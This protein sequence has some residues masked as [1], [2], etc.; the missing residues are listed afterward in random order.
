MLTY[1]GKSGNRGD[2]LI[3]VLFAVAIFSLVAVG[4]LSIMNQGTATAQRSLEIT[5]VRQ[6]IDAQAE[7]L[8]YLNASYIVG[9]SGSSEWQQI[10]NFAQD[11]NLTASAFNST[12]CVIPANTFILNT[13]T[14]KYVEPSG[15]GKPGFATTY[16]Q[17]RYDYNANTNN[18]TIHSVEGIWI[19]PV[20]SPT[21]IIPDQADAGYID[22][23][24]RACWDS[25]GQ[26][27]PITIGTIVRLYEPR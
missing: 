15:V 5:L 4:S 11:H 13:H 26:P 8:R 2:T 25:P 12:S 6:Q 14:A 17:V 9:G 3:E 24:I 7:T 20:Y 19:E 23:H 18:Y 21:S 10:H 16:S 1:Q 22:F 27:T